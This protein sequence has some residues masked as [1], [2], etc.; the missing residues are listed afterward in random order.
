MGRVLRASQSDV[1]SLL[2]LLSFY[3]ARDRPYNT[4]S[5]VLSYT[6]LRPGSVGGTHCPG[7]VHVRLLTLTARFAALQ[8]EG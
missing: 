8:C 2:L 3:T 5:F 6:T 7:R 1:Q 4:H